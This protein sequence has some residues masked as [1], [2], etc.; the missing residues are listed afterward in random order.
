MKMT[1]DKI[2]PELRAL[3]LTARVF[4]F[5]A[6]KRFGFKLFN[7]ASKRMEG[8]IAKGLINEKWSIKS[9]HGGPDI[10]LRVY[11]LE[12]N[13]EK[14][15]VL[16]YLHGGGY[17]VGA[18]EDSIDFMKRFMEKRPCVV[19]AP[20]YRKSQ[21]EPYPAAFND[22]YDTLLWV[23]DNAEAINGDASKI[24]VAGH[25]AGGGLTAAVTLKARDT[26]DVD[27]SF[28]MPIYPMIDD[29]HQTES[30][31]FE[32]PVWGMKSNHLGW[33]IYLRGLH[34]QNKEIPAYAAPARN[35]DY[36]DFPPTLTFVGGIDPFRDETIAYVEGLKQAG[37]PVKFTVFDGCYHGFEIMDPDKQVSKE[38]MNFLYDSYAE[39]YDQYIVNSFRNNK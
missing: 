5:L 31:Q 33:E 3:T 12:D 32:S 20:G 7:Q 24:M 10:R 29:R 34:R 14:L 37:I 16:L 35:E 4:T 11:R 38:A 15:P 2:H 19:V 17:A 13:T 39:Y 23:R 25:S 9:N 27:I 30:S 1:K 28:Q 6:S 21:E 8:K 26:K 18:P 22:C 36:S